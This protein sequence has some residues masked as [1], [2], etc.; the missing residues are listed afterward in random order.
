MSGPNYRFHPMS[1]P[2]RLRRSVRAAGE[3]GRYMPITAYAGFEQSVAA[4]DSLV[5]MCGELRR[6]RGLGRRGRLNATDQDL[7]WLPRS[8]VVAAMSADD[9]YIHDALREQQ[10]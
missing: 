8:A 2:S 5:E 4:A 6:L 3:P 1:W 7:R 9:A 10:P